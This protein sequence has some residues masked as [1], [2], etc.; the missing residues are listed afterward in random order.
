MRSKAV[1]LEFGVELEK[2]VL[3]KSGT[4]EDIALVLEGRKDIIG[5]CADLVLTASREMKNRLEFLITV[6]ND[7]TF[8]G[9][10]TAGKYDWKS[11]FVTAKRFPIKSSESGE[12]K[13][14]LLHF[15]RNIS[16]K[17][18]IT[19]AAKLGLE[20]PTYEDCL[21]FGAQHPEVQRQFRVV[22]LHDPVRGDGGNPNVLCLSSGGSE[23]GLGYD[24][25][26]DAWYGSC[27]FAF[28]CK[29]A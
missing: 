2:R 20:R 7:E 19:E 18:A 10:V 12:R 16:S 26:V 5:Q 24:W 11:D 1:R 6:E 14:V 8:E 13:L 25:F 22:F 23:R 15:G 9:L 21:R 29:P 28:V 3:A 27:R 4:R 17:D